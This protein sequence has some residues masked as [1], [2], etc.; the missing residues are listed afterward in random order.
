M[1]LL[2]FADPKSIGDQRTRH[3]DEITVARAQNG[4]GLIRCCDAT[5][6]HHRQINAR[7]DLARRGHLKTVFLRR[8]RV[9]HHA[10]QVGTLGARDVVQLARGCQVLRNFSPLHRAQSALHAIVAVQSQSDDGVSAHF[11]TCG[12]DDAHHDAHAIFQ[13]AAVLVITVVGGRRQ[14]LVEQ[15][16][17]RSRPQ[18][19]TVKVTFDRMTRGQPV[20]M[21]D[22][23]NILRL[24]HLR[25]LTVHRTRNRRRRPDWHAAGHAV[26]LPAAV[27]GLG[28][29][30]RAM[31]VHCRGDLA[32]L[33]DHARVKGK[34]LPGIG[35]SGLMDR[36]RLHRDHGSAA[37]GA[38]D[39][40]VNVSIG[41]QM[42]F[43][44]QGRVAGHPD[45]VLGFMSANLAGA[46]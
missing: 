15:I 26:G 30:Q 46:K 13:G 10:V 39:V 16:A 22:L 18:L 12:V 17:M 25:H 36:H 33:T 19:D 11:F 45:A 20:A 7:L 21:N 37:F 23:L 43:D 35:L 38:L 6:P 41:E 27:P 31:V 42:V 1:S 8:G 9:N 29:D 5:H 4:F 32:K 3:P 28:Q 14:E 24:H 40:V 2:G 34:S 44:Q